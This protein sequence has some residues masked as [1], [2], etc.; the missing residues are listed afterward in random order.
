MVARLADEGP[1]FSVIIPTFRRPERAIAAA[2]SIHAQLFSIRME[3]ILVDNDPDG[4]ALDQLQCFADDTWVFTR[5]LHQPELGVASARNMGVAAARGR[6]IAFLD[7][8][9][10]ASV[11]WLSELARVQAETSAD[12][13]FGPVRT[14]LESEPRAH[15]EHFEAFFARDPGHSEGIIQNVYGC[16][17]SLIRRNV[18]QLP[19]P[20]STSRNEIGGEDDLLFQQLKSEACVFAWAPDAV[21]WET[22]EPSRVALSYTLRRAFSYGQG[23]STS[24]WTGSPRSLSRVLYWMFVGAGQAVVFGP[25]SLGAFV[26]RLKNR[27][28]VYQRFVEGLGKVFWFSWIKPR[29][30]GAARLK[31]SA[32]S[33]QASQTSE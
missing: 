29:F 15:R 28:S 8:D 25:L 12:V 30:Y 10:V 33:S 5:I 3:L 14:R 31:A 23:P 1:E 7:D 24:A 16:G 4:G 21:V 22:P 32:P 27:A 26:L 20:F 13:V 18:L 2:D 17:N 6:F 11:E 19:E 9:E